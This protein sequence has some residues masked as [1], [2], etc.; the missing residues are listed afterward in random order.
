MASI[1]KVDQIQLP[2]GSAPTASD[3][4]VDVS[5]SVLQVVSNPQD[6]TFTTS[7]GEAYIA[8]N[9][10]CSVT[11]KSNG[12]RFKVTAHAP[13]NARPAGSNAGVK[14]YVSNDTAGTGFAPFGD[15]AVSTLDTH[16]GYMYSSAAADLWGQY[17]LE[18]MGSV[19]YSLG[20]TLTFKIYFTAQGPGND[21]STTS[22]H[23]HTSHLEQVTVTEIA[24]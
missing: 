18:L 11:P 19:A 23:G 12:S 13:L 4:G 5:G 9:N 1:L 14:L 7:A 20:D 8:T 15:G 6:S 17:F 2:D 16:A 22:R 10:T 3:L 24:Q 21:G